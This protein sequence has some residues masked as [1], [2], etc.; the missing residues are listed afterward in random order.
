MALNPDFI[1]KEYP[2]TEP[3]LIGREK[4]REFA[5]AIGDFTPVFHDVETAAEGG[6]PDL[7]TPPT[8]AF[9]L[10]MKAMA[11]AMFDPELGLNYALVVHGEQSFEYQRPL[12]AGDEVVVKS[13]IADITSRGRNEYLVT[14]ADVVTVSGELVVSTRS[15]IVSR[16]TAA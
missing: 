12:H 10:T 1:G 14:Q 6:Y 15:V 8:F 16:G 2:D 9:V 11:A 3:Y 7:P 5:T 4:V 13:H